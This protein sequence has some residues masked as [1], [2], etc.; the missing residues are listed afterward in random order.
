MKDRNLKFKNKNKKGKLAKKIKQVQKNERN[1]AA[2]IVNPEITKVV[3][4]KK[5]GQGKKAESQSQKGKKQQPNQGKQ[6]LNKKQQAKSKSS[7]RSNN[8]VNSNKNSTK[9]G[10]SNVQ[11][12]KSKKEKKLDNKAAKLNLPLDRKVKQKKKKPERNGNE[13]QKTASSH[14]LDVQRLQELLTNKQREKKKEKKNAKPQPL[15]D[16][17]MVKLRASRFRYLNETLYNNQSS[18]SKQFFKNDPDAFKA[19]HEGYK[20]QIEQ[21][22]MNPLDVIVSSIKKM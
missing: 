5:K 1:A 19:Y 4:K 7:D 21:W 2:S 18:E 9:A 13:S 11:K 15:R 10:K 3:N 16:R 17:M 14:N 22:P 8:K 6:K 20:Q 12:G